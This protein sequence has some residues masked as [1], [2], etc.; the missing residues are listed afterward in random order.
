MMLLAAG[1]TGILG[2]IFGAA[3]FFMLQGKFK[4]AARFL[5]ILLVVG[6]AVGGFHSSRHLSEVL[7]GSG[8]AGSVTGRSDVWARAGS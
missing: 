3:V 2:C 1:K 7:L 6:G 4:A 8:Q 5:L